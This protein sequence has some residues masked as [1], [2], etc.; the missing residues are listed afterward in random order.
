M[1][2]VNNHKIT[3]RIANLKS[4]K[5]KCSRQKLSVVSA[6]YEARIQTS[7]SVYYDLNRSRAAGVSDVCRV[8]RCVSVRVSGQAV[9]VCACVVSGGVCLCV[10]RVRRCVSDVCRVRRCVSVRVSCQAVCVC[11]CVVSGGVCLCVCL[12]LCDIET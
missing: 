9:C 5:L 3:I 12:I 1:H 11:A 6:L 2:K 10:C 7:V 8:R 4:F